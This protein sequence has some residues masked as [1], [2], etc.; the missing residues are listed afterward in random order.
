[1]NT[2]V[3]ALLSAEST[4]TSCG[5]VHPTCCGLRG[6]PP[7][8]SGRYRELLLQGARD[9]DLRRFMAEH[10]ADSK[11]VEVE[12][13]SILIDM[14]TEADYQRALRFVA[15]DPEAS[16]SREDSLYLLD[17]LETPDRVRKHS[18]TVS[19]AGEALARALKPGVPALDIQLV[20]SAGLLHDLARTRSDHATVGAKVL[21]NLGLHRLASVVGAHMTL[22]TEFLQADQLNEGHLVYLAD[23]LVV[24]DQVVGLEKRAERTL[25]GAGGSEADPQALA[26]MEARM[27]AA[28]AIQDKLEDALSEPLRATLARAGLWPR[29]A[30]RP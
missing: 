13:L 15:F 10:D 24:D 18:L 16:L 11:E 6:H 1:M 26:N 17:L 5:I 9:Q 3:L 7:L 23:K 14:D 19:A 12:D 25:G 27:F 28:Q 20:S 30:L 2:R 22:P 21:R 8:V 4:A 29:P